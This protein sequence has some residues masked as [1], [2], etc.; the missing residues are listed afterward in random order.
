MAPSVPR[1]EGAQDRRPSPGAELDGSTARNNRED[2]DDQ[3]DDKDEPEKAANSRAAGD[4][5]NDQGDDENP[6]Q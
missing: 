5:Q 3:G 4:R 6:E 1:L 2:R